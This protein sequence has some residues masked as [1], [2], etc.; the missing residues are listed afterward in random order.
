[1][2]G[3]AGPAARAALVGFDGAGYVDD[4]SCCASNRSPSLLLS[5]VINPVIRHR[6]TRCFRC[7]Q[8]T[9]RDFWAHIEALQ[10]GL[11]LQGETTR[12]STFCQLVSKWLSGDANGQWFLVL[13]N[14]DNVETFSPKKERYSDIEQPGLAANLP[15][16]SNG[17][18]RA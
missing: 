3:C 6:R 9:V 10:T 8:V 12:T 11:R 1:M 17:F 15:Q 13:D 16:T 2:R 14:V 4:I 7:P 5:T 18:A